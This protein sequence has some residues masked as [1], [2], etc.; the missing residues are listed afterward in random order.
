MKKIG[1]LWMRESKDGKKYASGKVL[2]NGVE[3]EIVVFSNERKEKE[4][5]PDKLIYLSEKKEQQ[6]VEKPAFKIT[7]QAFKDW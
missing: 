6:V 2:V 5:Q 4:T 3:V 1:G 7:K